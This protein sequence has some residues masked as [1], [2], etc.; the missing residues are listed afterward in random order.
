[1][2]P[3]DEPQSFRARSIGVSLTVKDLDKSVDW[4]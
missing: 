1:M 3:R 2:K 4:Y